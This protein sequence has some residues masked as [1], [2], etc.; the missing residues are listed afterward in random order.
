[1]EVRTLTPHIGAEILDVDVSQSLSNKDFAA[2]HQTHLDYMVLVFPGQQL[3]REQHKAFAAKFGVL[4][5]IP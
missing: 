3:N 1:M 5:S 2:I 4:Q